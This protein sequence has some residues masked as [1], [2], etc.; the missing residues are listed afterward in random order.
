[1]PFRDIPKTE[2]RDVLHRLADEHRA[3]PATVDRDGRV[4]VC[5]QP[6][7]SISLEDG[8]DLCLGE[9]V[10]HVDS[11]RALRIQETRTDSNRAA[12]T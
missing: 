1:M 11:P 8:V 6:L 10:V 9:S 2:W 3:W 5:D 7:R 4:E 12:S